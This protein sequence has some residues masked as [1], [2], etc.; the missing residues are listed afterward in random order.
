MKYKSRYDLS[1]EMWV[2]I[3][4]T[5]VLLLY[6]VI[7]FTLLFL[8]FGTNPLEILPLLPWQLYVVIGGILAALYLSFV[9]IF[10][11]TKKIC[12]FD[13]NEITLQDSA[14]TIKIAKSEIK[15]IYYAKFS[16]FLVP[17]LYNYYEIAMIFDE[18]MKMFRQIMLF[19]HTVKRLQKLGYPVKYDKIL[20][21]ITDG[22]FLYNEKGNG[23]DGNAIIELSKVER[24]VL[25]YDKDVTIQADIRTSDDAEISQRISFG[26]GYRKAET[27]IKQLPK[28]FFVLVFLSHSETRRAKRHRKFLLERG[29]ISEEN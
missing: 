3:I 6:G 19:P 20:L 21:K 10:F 13:E 4:A 1:V 11:L 8:I 28:E 23:K 24:I 26:K 27:L 16:L 14:K 22:E 25:S 29:L 7:F 17:F 5:Q 9:L 2:V 15:L 12:I 18:D